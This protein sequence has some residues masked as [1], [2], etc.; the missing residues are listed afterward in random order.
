MSGGE[1][2]AVTAPEVIVALDFP[3]ADAA[4]AM[5]GRLPEGTWVKVG[6]EL[7]TAAGPAVV[8]RLAERGHPVFLDLKVHDIP[9]T[10][11]G[12]VRSAARLGARLL[13]VHA[14]GGRAMLEAAAGAAATAGPDAGGRLRLLAVTVLTSLDDTSLAEVMGRGAGTEEAVGRL[15]ALAS[16]SGVDGA[17]A[18][19]AECRAVKAVCG[20]DF[21]VATP[22]IRLA[23]GDAH[24]QKRVA[25]PGE[26][27]AAGADYLVVGRAITA[28]DDP[29]A[30]LLRVREEAGVAE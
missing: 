1:E 14:S 30:A 19:V 3:T 2:G 28:T 18:S 27:R 22:G 24:D 25:T 8:E 21:L 11:A 6:L 29:G 10:A 12:A 9:N 5:A 17:V 20:A 16:G 7:F 15:A 23:G 26:A 4:L 13:T